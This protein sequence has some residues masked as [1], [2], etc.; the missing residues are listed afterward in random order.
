MSLLDWLKPRR[1]APPPPPPPPLPD[2]GTF[3]VVIELASFDKGGLEKVVLDSALSFD[4]ARVQTLI[5]SVGPLGHLAGVAQAAGLRVV[6]LPASGGE[7]AY[8]ELLDNFRPALAVSHFSS[9]GYKLFAA[10]KIP[11][12]SYIH[13][14]YAFFGDEQRRRFAADD[15]LVSRYVSVSPKA[16]A[17]AV[18]RLGISPA[19]IETI[20]NG[21]DVA[22]YERRAAACVPV[23]RAAL[24]IA[25]GDYVFLNVASYNLHKGHYVMAAAMRRLLAKRRDIRIVCVGNTVY[26]PHV[27]ALRE[28]LREQGLD[29]HMLM[30][31]YVADVET[32]YGLADAFLLPSF[33]EGWSI[34]MNEAMFFGK[35]MILTDTGAASEVIES[36][37]I[38]ILLPNEFGAVTEL[39]PQLLDELAY[40]GRD[41]RVAGALADAMEQFADHRAHWAQAGLGGRAKLRARYN[42]PDIARR[43]EATMRGVAQAR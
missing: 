9:A 40:N 17:Y 22:E 24:G 39:T 43:Y 28:M 18:A 41:F 42:L 15:R 10:R 6:G 31:G 1:P 2:D 33:I 12:L 37:D 23:S 14:V 36:D 16:T 34:A 35:P 11:I 27:A 13:N 20:P 38:G 21:L 32:M 30:P 29:R 4:R 19:R 26:P 25:D 5:V 8:A 7:R 3:R